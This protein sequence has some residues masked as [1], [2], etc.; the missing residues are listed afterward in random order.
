MHACH[1][2]RVW[3]HIPHNVTQTSTLLMVTLISTMT[4][5]TLGQINLSLSLPIVTT[6]IQTWNLFIS[7]LELI[8]CSFGSYENK[9]KGL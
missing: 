9:T 8:Y 4:W 5:T 1:G 7:P 6:K 2:L 3:V